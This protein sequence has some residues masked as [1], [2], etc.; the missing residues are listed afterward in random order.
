MSR[1][2]ELTS[3]HLAPG[4]GSGFRL[5]LWPLDLIGAKSYKQT[6]QDP[7][8]PPSTRTTSTSTSLPFKVSGTICITFIRAR[9]VTRLMAQ[10]KLPRCMTICTVYPLLLLLQAPAMHDHMHRVPSPSPAFPT[11]YPTYE[12]FQQSPLRSPRPVSPGGFVIPQHGYEPPIPPTEWDNRGRSRERGMDLSKGYTA[13]HTHQSRRHH[14]Q[15]PVYVQATSQETRQNKLHKHHHHDRHHRPASHGRLPNITIHANGQTY[16]VPSQPAHQQ[17]ASAPAQVVYGTPVAAH[18]VRPSHSAQ[19]LPHAHAAA[20]RTY[21]L[22]LFSEIALFLDLPF[23]VNP[24]ELTIF[25]AHSNLIPTTQ[26][27]VPRLPPKDIVYYGPS[28]G[29]KRHYFQYSQCSRRKKALCIG[30]N[31]TGQANQLNG[32]INDARRMRSFLIKRYGFQ[33]GDIVLL[34]DEGRSQRERPTRRNIIDAMKWLVRGAQANDSLVFHFSGH[35]GQTPDQDGDEIDGYDETIFPLDWKKTGHIVDDDMHT[36]MVRPLPA[37]CRLTAI[38]DCCHSGSALDLPYT[39]STNG[40][41]KREPNLDRAAGADTFGD[42]PF[43][44]GQL[45]MENLT[46]A[47]A[48]GMRGIGDENRRRKYAMKIKTSPADVICW[49]GCKDS[50]TSAD[51]YQNNEATGAMSYAFTSS[52]KAKPDQ[53]YQELLV[54]I[55]RILKHRFSQKPQLSASHPIDTSL[56]FVL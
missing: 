35:G 28:I 29:N 47:F 5:T 51:T 39:Y 18:R 22:I 37:G 23:T 3:N 38:F 12:A 21:F 31:Y 54:N 6:S 7:P 36:L 14:D 25:T 24:G 43:I 55:R 33:P 10:F 17:G 34:T 9:A 8:P 16:A 13:V 56:K 4:S 42:R 41:L 19:Q 40:K 52:L 53:T 48:D 15:D 27:P 49:A 2:A 1:V 44:D 32:C 45:S 20:S 50:Q 11:P 46:Q 30:I 26:M